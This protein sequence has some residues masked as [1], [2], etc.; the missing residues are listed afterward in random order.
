MPSVDQIITTAAHISK[1]YC[2]DLNIHT[3]THTEIKDNFSIIVII[4]IIKQNTDE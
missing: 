3:K 4:I 2:D 1:F